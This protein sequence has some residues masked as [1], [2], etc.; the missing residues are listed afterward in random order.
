M[1][2]RQSIN[3]YITTIGLRTQYIPNIKSDIVN[4]IFESIPVPILYDEGDQVILTLLT[5]EIADK[6]DNAVDA[7]DNMITIKDAINT[8]KI[9]AEYKLC[10]D[11]FHNIIIADLN[12][13]ESS[14]TYINE[15]YLIK[16]NEIE[17]MYNRTSDIICN[18]KNL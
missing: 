9:I 11:K 14:I 1:S 17:Q 8:R 6:Y 4:V 7:I 3:E 16:I 13:N 10:I 5:L 12:N 18:N 2:T 15:K